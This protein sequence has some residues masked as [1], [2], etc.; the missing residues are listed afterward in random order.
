MEQR[1]Q[2]DH[3]DASV[4]LQQKVLH[5]IINFYGYTF[6]EW[7]KHKNFPIGPD[8]HP[9][10]KAHAEAAKYINMVTTEGKINGH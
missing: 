5:Y 10:E 3:R 4:E 2:H 6:L 8:G 7:S 1:W 9:L